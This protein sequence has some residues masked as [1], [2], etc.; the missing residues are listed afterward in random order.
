MITDCF[1]R[2]NRVLPEDNLIFVG[3]YMW[4][5]LFFRFQGVSVFEI[6]KYTYLFYLYHLIIKTSFRTIGSQWNVIERKC[7]RWEQWIFSFYICSVVKINLYMTPEIRTS[8]EH[9]ISFLLSNVSMVVSLSGVRFTSICLL[10][11]CCDNRDGMC[12]KLLSTSC[13]CHW[14]FIASH[15]AWYLRETGPGSKYCRR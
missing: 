6:P 3:E 13:V 5:N 7:L 12:G 15:D 9:C 8:I 1:D 4:H 2:Q 14:Q 11:C 10:L